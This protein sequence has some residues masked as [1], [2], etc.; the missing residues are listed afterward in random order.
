MKKKTTKTKPEIHVTKQYHYKAGKGRKTID[1]VLTKAN[2]TFW[3]VY[4]PKVTQRHI[5]YIKDTK[6]NTVIAPYVIQCV[7]RPRGELIPSY[8]GK[9]ET[10]II[11]WR[12]IIMKMYDPIVPSTTQAV[13][14]HLLEGNIP[15]TITI[16]VLG[17]VGDTVEEWEIKDATIQK[18]GFSSL[19]WKN[20]GDPATVEVEWKSQNIT[21]KY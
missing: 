2:E 1:A 4:E 16:K 17:P 19:D 10:S 13:M 9:V 14:K 5:V 15:V 3:T 6:N 12:P 11:H 7:D 21:L 8:N 18:F 20:T